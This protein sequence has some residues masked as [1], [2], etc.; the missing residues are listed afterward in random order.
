MSVWVG[1]SV[2]AMTLTLAPTPQP[3][4]PSMCGIAVVHDPLGPDTALGERMLDR[5]SHR[6]P[7]GTRR[8]AGRDHLAG[9]RTPLHRRPRR[10]ATSRCRPATATGR[11]CNGEIYNH[12]RLR[13]VSPRRRSA[14][15]PTPRPRC[16]AAISEDPDALGDLRGMYAFAVADDDGDL[17]VARDPVGVKPLYWA[18]VG[19][20]TLLRLRDPGLRRGPPAPRRGVPARAPVDADPTGS[21]RFRELHVAGP[22]LT[23]RDRG[24]DAAARHRSTLAVRRRMMADVPIGVFLSGGLDSSLVAALMAA[25]REDAHGPVH[26]FAAGTAGVERPRRRPPGR[27][28]TS[29]SSTTSAC[30]TPT[31]WSRCCRRWCAAIESYEPSLVRSAVPNYLLSEDTARHGQGGAH[32]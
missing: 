19:S 21:R 13:E 27:R 14:P 1:V 22:E 5:I 31:R 2:L 3:Y 12:E 8:P 15:T 7:D 17:V 4:T 28:R 11:S 24:G 6:G 25:H 20:A 30:T 9:P 26:S 23:D 16:A 29:A 32:R 18:R 10:A